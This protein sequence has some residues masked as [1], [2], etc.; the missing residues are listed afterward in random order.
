MIGAWLAPIV[1]AMVRVSP[2]V[3]IDSDSRCP[4]A[5]MVAGALAALGDPS[6]TPELSVMIRSAGERLALEFSWRGRPDAEVR[7]LPDRKSVV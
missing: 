2:T 4:S 6:R 5:E 7:E 1:I 3:T